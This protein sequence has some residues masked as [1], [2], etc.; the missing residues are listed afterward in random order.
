M[1]A[2]ACPLKLAHACGTTHTVL[3]K[4]LAY[5]SLD[6]IRHHRALT[7]RGMELGLRP[8]QS[9][10]SL[11]VAHAVS[12]KTDTLVLPHDLV[13]RMAADMQLLRNLTFRLALDP[14]TV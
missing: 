14:V 4:A 6:F 8:Y 5:Q 13:D 10:E 11:H 7:H 3:F 12:I 1:D 9:R 2:P